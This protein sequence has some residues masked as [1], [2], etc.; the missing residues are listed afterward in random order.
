MLD[1]VKLI[2][3][4][5]GAMV[6]EKDVEAWTGGS[7]NGHRTS[8]TYFLTP[9]NAQLISICIFSS[10]RCVCQCLYDVRSFAYYTDSAPLGGQNYHRLNPLLIDDIAIDDVESMSALIE[11]A[12][13]IDLTKTIG[14]VR[15]HVTAMP[16]SKELDWTK[17]KCRSGSLV[18]GKQ[19]TESSIAG[20]PQSNK[21]GVIEQLDSKPQQA[22]T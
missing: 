10:I 19:P 5:F 17:W 16:S 8:L 3:S 7:H 1:N 9:A 12:D 13:G 2:R 11:I 22:V 6:L 4:R 14:F 15:R 18:C 20:N 21:T